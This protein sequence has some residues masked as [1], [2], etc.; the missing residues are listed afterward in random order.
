MSFPAVDRVAVH[1]LSETEYQ[2]TLIAPMRLIDEDD[3]FDAVDLSAY[4]TECLR[5]MGLS[6]RLEEVDIPYVYLSGD[7]RFTHVLL[8][9]GKANTY[10]VLI[11]DNTLHAIRGHFQLDL[12][13]KY[14]MPSEVNEHE[15]D[16]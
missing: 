16:H 15:T 4:A 5:T 6:V 2:S 11:V 8:S 12:N 1:L 13:A 7:A 3:D 10:L 14:G 9:Y